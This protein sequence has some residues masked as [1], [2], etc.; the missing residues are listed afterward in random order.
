MAQARIDIICETC[1]KEFTHTKICFNR[2]EAD[3]YE[4][5]AKENIT[6]CPDCYKEA[7]RKF[8]E[9]KRRKA[10]T[11]NIMKRAWK[12]A[13]E[14]AEKF[15]GSPREY[16]RESLRMAWG[17]VKE[18]ASDLKG[19]EKQITWARKIKES[20][21]AMLFAGMKPEFVPEAI[22]LANGKTSAAW[23]IDNKDMFDSARGVGRAIKG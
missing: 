11:G 15:G 5:W 17:E 20:A 2:K 22:K 14:G 13:R 6:V 23:W 10:L 7:C 18:T 4:E 1:G 12:I 9:K 16:F 8:E 21:L 3:S 19:S